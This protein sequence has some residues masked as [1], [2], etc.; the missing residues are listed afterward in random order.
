MI[1]PS[2]INLRIFCPEIYLKNIGIYFICYMILIQI[3]DWNWC[4][5]FHLFHL[6]PTIPFSYRIALPKRQAFFEA[7]TNCK[8]KNKM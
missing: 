7:L 1:K 8:D 2:L 3:T 5:K 6:D 4:W